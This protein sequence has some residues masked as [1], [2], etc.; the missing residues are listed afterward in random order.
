MNDT[1]YDNT[2]HVQSFLSVYNLKNSCEAGDD[3][4]FQKFL[5][6]DARVHTV[7]APGTP[8]PLPQCWV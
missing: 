2:S 7:Y 6:I 1:L 5:E 4:V 8:F 3:T